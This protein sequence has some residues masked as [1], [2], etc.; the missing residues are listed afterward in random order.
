MVD[1]TG[2]ARRTVDHQLQ[3]FIV[4]IQPWL[5]KKALNICK[6]ATDAKD[7]VQEASA[8]F[9][10][11]FEGA[12]ALPQE[13]Y[14]E[15]WLIATMSN[16]FVDL[17]RKRKAEKQGAADPTLGR[18]TVG[19]P[20]EEPKLLSETISDED[21]ATVMRR[22]SPKLRATFEM[23]VAGHS[24]QDISQTLGIPIGR[25]GKR[26][27]DA[28]KKLLSMLEPILGGGGH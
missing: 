10:K 12:T 13:N 6:D 25:V 23:R 22:L 9:L 2:T 26:L 16:C 3:L 21:F 17:C 20:S 5:R 19:H 7:L 27:S 4:G 14:I 15:R 28:R 1:R 8:R 18:M 24:Y 11:T